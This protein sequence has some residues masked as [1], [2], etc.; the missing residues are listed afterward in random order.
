MK[1]ERDR[2]T[3]G[4]LGRTLFKNISPTEQFIFQHVVTAIGL[5]A[6][7]NDNFSKKL[8]RCFIPLYYYPKDHQPSYWSPHTH[9]PEFTV[10]QCTTRVLTQLC[11]NTAQLS[12]KWPANFMCFGGCD[13]FK[14]PKDWGLRIDVET[15][16]NRP[17]GSQKWYDDDGV[18]KLQ[19]AKHFLFLMKTRLIEVLKSD[20]SGLFKTQ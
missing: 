19:E 17:R 14:W 10:L 15:L 2:T 4:N 13:I 3:L 8:D 6:P 12:R 5:T 9:Q 11:R 7:S 18:W 16:S 20:M 1:M